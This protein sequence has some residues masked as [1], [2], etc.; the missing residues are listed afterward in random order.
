MKPSGRVHRLSVAWRAA[1]LV[2]SVPSVRFTLNL[3]SLVVLGVNGF[4]VLMVLVLGKPGT[5]EGIAQYALIETPMGL[6]VVENK[7]GGPMPD[8]VI[9]I[10]WSGP[11]NSGLWAPTR[12]VQPFSSQFTDTHKST[13][14]TDHEL[15]SRIFDRIE[16]EGT[17]VPLP[18]ELIRQD[19]AGVRRVVWWGYLADAATLFSLCWPVFA[20][21]TRREYKR[22]LLCA[23]SGNARNERGNGAAAWAH[24]EA[25][26]A[27]SRIVRAA[28]VPGARRTMNALAIIV[29]LLNLLV[30]VVHVA[31]VPGSALAR[32]WTVL[33]YAIMAAA[34]PAIGWVILAVATQGR[35]AR[36]MGGRDRAAGMVPPAQDV[37]KDRTARGESPA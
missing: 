21:A 18:R 35:Y 10:T 1:V 17:Q 23:G 2:A 15:R 5:G 3:L 26:R 16:R 20:I 7:L 37:P 27:E 4:V 28:M 25:R 24:V 29:L 6:E 33:A 13:I 14:V 34:A 31:P 9:T 36:R 12:S 19:R 22:R 32:A 30:A 11:Y 8:Y